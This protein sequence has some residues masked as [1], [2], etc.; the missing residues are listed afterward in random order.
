LETNQS[1]SALSKFL[2]EKEAQENEEISQDF[3]QESAKIQKMQKGLIK[4]LE[5][6]LKELEENCKIKD[7][8][9]LCR[10]N[11][12]KGIYTEIHNFLRYF[13]KK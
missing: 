5:K 4:K 10:L 11:E 8:A 12:L 2:E 6:D 9:Q 7:R 1:Y 3:L 13:M